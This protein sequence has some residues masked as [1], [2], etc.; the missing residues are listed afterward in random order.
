M[1]SDFIIATAMPA[2][3][4]QTPTPEGTACTPFEMGHKAEEAGEPPRAPDRLPVAGPANTVRI[5]L[6]RLDDL[7][8]WLAN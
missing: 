2:D 7:V 3:E 1:A 5:D 6:G 4:L 8:R